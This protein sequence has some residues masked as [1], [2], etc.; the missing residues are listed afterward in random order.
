MGKRKRQVMCS[1]LKM[2]VRGSWSPMNQNHKPSI[3]FSSLNSSW[4]VGLVS[5]HGERTIPFALSPR[6]CSR[7]CM[8]AQ[9]A[10]ESGQ[11]IGGSLNGW[12][13]KLQSITQWT[14]TVRSNFR[15]V[16]WFMPFPIGD[17]LPFL[18]WTDLQ[19]KLLSTNQSFCAEGAYITLK[20]QQ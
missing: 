12:F 9:K 13:A 20:T 3:N 10:L 2:V 16:V 11:F 1:N 18:D 7:S 6:S 4:F 14:S 19:R 5:F 17:H 8:W 15:F